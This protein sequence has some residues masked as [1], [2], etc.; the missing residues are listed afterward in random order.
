MADG[1]Q[2]LQAPWLQGGGSNSNPLSLVNDVMKLRQGMQEFNARQSFGQIMAGSATPEEAMQKWQQSGQAGFFP[3]AMTQMRTQALLGAQTTEATA[4]ATREQMGLSGD[5]YGGMLHTG[6]ISTTPEDFD[7]NFKAQIALMPPAVRSNPAV[8]E[9]A[10][11]YYKSRMDGLPPPGDPTRNAAYQQRWAASNGALATPQMIENVFGTQGIADMPGGGKLP[12]QRAPVWQGGAVTPTPMAPTPGTSGQSMSADDTAI[13]ARSAGDGKPL[14]DPSMI[15]R[16]SGPTGIGGVP[17]LNQQQADLEKD[18]RDAHA[19][20]MPQ[21][22]AAQQMQGSLREMDRDL[23]QMVTLDGG[24]GTGWTAP[25]PTQELRNRLAAGVNTAFQAVGAAP[26]V[27][28]TKVAA[29]EDYYKNADRLAFQFA[30]NYQGAGREGIQS[31]L[32]AAKAVPGENSYLGAKLLV[33]STDVMAQRTQ[34][35]HD[36]MTLY[37]KQN[38]GQMY[39]AEVA[40]NKAHPVRD[41]VDGMMSEFGMKGD[42]KFN[43]VEDLVH[44]Q[45]LGL[46]TEQQIRTIAKT[47]F[48]DAL[49]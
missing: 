32:Q 2:L 22:Q 10:Q 4:K 18:T 28:P 8:Q 27:D 48:P 49:K 6:V 5:I 9:A 41:Y 11:S 1:F 47:Q 36:F 16:W 23:D 24:K 40:F 30:N 33:R 13:M 26:P 29:I 12:F 14:L 39:G 19:K 42:G 3:D 7:R 20:G 35:L 37:A 34:D 25:G 44:M 38:N 17:V 46:L 21:Y 43:S 45:K 15:T 31:I